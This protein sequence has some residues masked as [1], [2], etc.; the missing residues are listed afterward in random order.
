MRQICI[1]I[2]NSFVPW[3]NHLIFCDTMGVEYQPWRAVMEVQVLHGTFLGV[4]I[5][6]LDI[7]E[8]LLEEH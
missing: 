2:L 8:E 3:P 4:R 6:V 7:V 5:D 1:W